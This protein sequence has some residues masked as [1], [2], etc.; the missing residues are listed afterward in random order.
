MRVIN[1]LNRSA[2]QPASIRYVNHSITSKISNKALLTFSR[3]NKDLFNTYRLS[4]L[5]DYL[6]ISSDILNKIKGVLLIQAIHL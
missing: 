1:T 2:A 5:G 4:R 3:G 6:P